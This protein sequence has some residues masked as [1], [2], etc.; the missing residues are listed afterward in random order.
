MNDDPAIMARLAEY[1]TDLIVAKSYEEQARRNRVAIE[2]KIAELIPTEV[3]GQ[4]TVA[5]SAETKLV[6]RREL[7]YRADIDAIE[8]I[9]ALAPQSKC[10]PIKTKT[11][12][13]L[14][15]S[16]YEW[17][18]NNSPEMFSLISQHVEVTSRKVSVVLK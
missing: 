7:S 1:A 12:R 6:V 10:V 11:T 13:E 5:I 8:D 2:E 14:D 16:G 9:F 3:P 18:K 15:I 4:R 17:Y